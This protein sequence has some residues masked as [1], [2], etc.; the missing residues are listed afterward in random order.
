LTHGNVC[1]LLVTNGNIVF[2]CY[3][4]DFRRRIDSREQYEEDWNTVVGL[5]EGFENAERRLF[6]ILFT[7][8]FTN[9]RC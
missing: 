7:H 4:L 5:G 3:T 8:H 1:E 2:G 6:D 9:K